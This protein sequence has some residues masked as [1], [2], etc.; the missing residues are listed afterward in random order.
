M[1]TKGSSTEVGQHYEALAC[2]TL[3]NAGVSVIC[4]NFRCAHGEIDIVAVDGN[5]LVAIEVKF[6][7]NQQFGGG[8]LAVSSTQ[9]RRIYRALCYYAQQHQCADWPLRIDIIAFDGA[10]KPQWL[11]NAITDLG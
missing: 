2:Q 10:T 4:Q 8:V 3:V 11:K 1:S 6:R 5:I 7:K 9:Q